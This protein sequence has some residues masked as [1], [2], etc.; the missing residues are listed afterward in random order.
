MERTGKAKIRIE[1]PVMYT[2]IVVNGSHG[3]E[4]MMGREKEFVYR[5]RLIQRNH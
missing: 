5:Y 1:L 4:Y 3:Q 2:Q